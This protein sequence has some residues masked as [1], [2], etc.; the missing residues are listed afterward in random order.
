[1]SADSRLTSS[2]DA[3]RLEHAILRA[4]EE[5]AGDLGADARRLLVRVAPIDAEARFVH[6]EEASLVEKAVESRRREFATGRRLAH[7]LLDAMGH[8]RAPLLPGSRRGPEW[9]KGVIGSISHARSVA[10]VVVAKGPPFT[11]IGLDVEGAEA[12]RAELID[13]VLTAH[14]RLELTGDAIGARAKLAFA[15]K[16]CAYKAWSPTLHAMPEFTDVEIDFDPQRSSFKARLLPR[17]ATSFEARSLRG[18][19]AR[20]GE[21][22]FAVSLAVDDRTEPGSPPPN[23][24][25]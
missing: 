24:S 18:R 16:E 9:P 1:M 17:S 5:L 20:C 21:R 3:A 19:Y 12:L 14:E 4:F 13:T 11:A 15:A 2:S 22:V 6:A 25:G 23:S 7:E 10:A 8:A